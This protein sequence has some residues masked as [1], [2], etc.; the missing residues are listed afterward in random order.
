[1]IAHNVH[2]RVW[3][4]LAGGVLLGLGSLRAADPPVFRVALERWAADNFDVVVFHRGS[5]R[6]EEQALVDGLKESSSKLGANLGVSTVDVASPMEDP[7]QTLWDA[8]TNP[9]A[10]WNAVRAPKSSE[11]APPVWAG[12]P[13]PA[14]ITAVIESPARRRI[15]ESL[16]RGD[17]AVWVL[18]ESGDTA[19]DEVAVDVLSAELKAL[20]RTLQ[21]PPSTTND[22]PM[23]SALPLHI[24]FSLVRVTRRDPAEGFF[25]T[26]LLYGEPFAPSKPIAFPVI[27]RGRALPPLIGRHLDEEPIR[28]ACTFIT[29][30]CLRQTKES[31]PGKD[32]LLAAKWTSIFDKPTP[33]A[34]ATTSSPQL[35]SPATAGDSDPESTF[36][37]ARDGATSRV[38]LGCG[39]VLV[40][41]LAGVFAWRWG[42]QSQP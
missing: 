22:P 42:R 40:V 8:Q 25:V 17:A 10:P 41:L 23:Q 2:E 1:M 34:P 14:P 29:G 12:P 5:F 30:S 36:P 31:N 21:L 4:L 35:L 39:A 6:T 20:E 19:R 18:L 9:P 28:E 11:D 38:W 24:A 27:G 3:L 32:L 7:M 26:L 33:T 16:L 15:A 37:S 13:T